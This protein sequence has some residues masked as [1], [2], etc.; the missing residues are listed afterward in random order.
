MT[1]I[2]HGR[3]SEYAIVETDE[4]KLK[5]TLSELAERFPEDVVAESG[6]NGVECYSVPW[7]WVKIKAPKS[8]TMSPEMREK[9]SNII[10]DAQKRRWSN[11]SNNI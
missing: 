10:R 2:Q 6:Q 7:L 4:V 9:M 5:H 3:G 11:S 1:N 8:K